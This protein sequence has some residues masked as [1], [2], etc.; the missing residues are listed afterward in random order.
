MH[1]MGRGGLGAVS[2]LAR[3]LFPCMLLVVA[4]QEMSLSFLAH[5]APCPGC[6]CAPAAPAVL[7]LCFNC[8]PLCTR[9]AFTAGAGA[10]VP[11]VPVL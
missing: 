1:G 11:P 8:R 6:V 3:L 2:R 7:T 9:R 5:P 10:I 4:S